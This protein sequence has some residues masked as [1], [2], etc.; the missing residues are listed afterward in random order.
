MFAMILA[1]LALAAGSV[2]FMVAAVFGFAAFA[3]LGVARA[4]RTWPTVQGRVVQDRK[5]TRLNS[6]H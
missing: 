4:S 5:S 2:L 3:A 1:L 6:S